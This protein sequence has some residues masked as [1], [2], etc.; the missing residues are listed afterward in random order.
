MKKILFLIF[1]LSLFGCSSSYQ[2]DK[3]SVINAGNYIVKTVKGFSSS[4]FNEVGALYSGEKPNTNLLIDGEF[5]TVGRP[6][7]IEEKDF[8]KKIESLDGVYY[9][10]ANRKIEAPKV[11]SNRVSDLK[12]FGLDQGNLDEDIEAACYEYALQITHARDWVDLNGTPQKGAYTEVGYGD[13]QVVIAIIDSG[14]NVNHKDFNRNGNSICL[15]AKS[16]YSADLDPQWEEFRE[17][18]SFRDVPQGKNEDAM[19]HGTHCSGTMC[20]VEGNNSGIAG[21]AYKNTYI[22]SYKIFGFQVGSDKGTSMAL[23]DLAE[24]T[25]ILKKDPATRSSEEIAKIPPSVPSNFKITQKTIPVNMSLGGYSLSQYEA[26]MINLALANDVLPVTAM[27]NDGRLQFFYPRSLKGCLA[28]GATTNQDKRAFFSDGGECISV[29]APGFDIVST[30]NGKWF[31]NIGLVAGS[32]SDGVRFMSGTSMAAPFV[33]G[34]IGYLLSFNEGQKLSSYQIK[35]ILEETADKV[36]KDNAPFGKYDSKGHSLYYGYGRVNVLKAASCVAQKAGATPIPQENSFYITK[37]LTITTPAP[38]TKV[39]L[40]EVLSDNSLYPQGISIT[41]SKN[42]T[43]F[44]GLTKDVKY[45]VR[46]Y[47]DDTLKEQDIIASESG[48]MAHTFN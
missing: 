42:K 44:Y 31:S 26:E 37:P 36:D 21:V 33:T 22:I 7:N 16:I 20:A 13:N 5:Y 32:D 9:A 18:N 12:T 40:Y 38:N 27:G 24:I 35:K 19:G 23:G 15:Y 29:V 47:V 14:L 48:A 11:F 25:K 34:T 41:D 39:Y 17:L 6:S 3:V 2:N 28:V 46:T 43:Y 4:Q 1:S 8:V 30:Y 45:R 10:C